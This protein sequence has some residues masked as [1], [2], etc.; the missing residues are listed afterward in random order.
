MNGQKSVFA[1]ETMGVLD[2][3]KTTRQG[4]DRR[5]RLARTT[6]LAVCPKGGQE[7]GGLI[8]SD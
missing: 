3:R 1:Q 6:R 7:F 5:Q 2:I 8:M 4:F